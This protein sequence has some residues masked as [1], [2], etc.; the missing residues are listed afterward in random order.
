MQALTSGLAFVPGPEAV[1]G[2]VLLAAAAQSGFVEKFV[3][4]MGNTGNDQEETL[5][6]LSANASTFMSKMQSNIAQTLPGLLNDVDTFAAT[7]ASGSMSQ[8]LPSLNDLPTNA[9][10]GLN[11]YVISQAYQARGV[12]ITRALNTS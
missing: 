11:T 3:L 12:F 9:Q 6:D 2:K 7:A 4:P 1:I 10:K 5:Q 8:F